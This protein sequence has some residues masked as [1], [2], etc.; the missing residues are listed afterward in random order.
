M[1]LITQSII[2]AG[3]AMTHRILSQYADA[4][5]TNITTSSIVIGG[6][7]VNGLIYGKN[8]HDNK[9]LRA[10]YGHKTIK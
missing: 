3:A 1:A 9:R 10:Y 8:Y 6:T 7:I 5:I 2:G 4:N